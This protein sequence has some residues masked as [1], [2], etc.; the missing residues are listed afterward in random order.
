MEPRE[1]A[2]VPIDAL[3]AEQFLHGPM[4]AFNEGDLLVAVAVPG[5]AYDRVAGIYAIT[6]AIS[7]SYWIV[8]SSVPATPRP[9][10]SHS[11]NSRRRFRRCW[12]SMPM[13]MLAYIMAVLRGTHPDAFRRNDPRYKEAFGLLA[14]LRI[15]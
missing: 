10:S 13:Q 1:A 14:L 4:V 5:N 7:S 15:S 8:G 2:Y 3:H 9:P 12:R 6:D 11:R